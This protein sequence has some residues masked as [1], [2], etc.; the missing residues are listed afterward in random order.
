MG[1]DFVLSN[2]NWIFGGLSAIAVAFIAFFARKSG[3]DAEKEKQRKAD[4]KAA[5]TVTTVRNDV[6]SDSD[7]SLEAR[8]R[9]WGSQ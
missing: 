7:E 9:K 1:L 4:Q 5:E 8:F 2:L 3:A 6:K